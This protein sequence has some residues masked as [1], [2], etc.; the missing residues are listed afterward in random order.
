MIQLDGIS[1]VSCQVDISVPLGEVLQM[2]SHVIPGY[3]VLYVLIKGS[4][5]EEQ[6]L[7]YDQDRTG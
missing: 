1:L 3:P 5:Y 2:E 7:Q 4:P 6:W